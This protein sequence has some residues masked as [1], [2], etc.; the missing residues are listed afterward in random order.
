MKSSLCRVVFDIVEPATF[1]GSKIAIGVM[2]PVLPTWQI[3]SFK[4]VSFFSGGYLYAIA[5]LGT[6]D[7]VP[8]SSLN[9]RL[10]TFITAPSIPNDSCSLF[11]PISFIALKAS[12]IL[13]HNFL[14]GT[15]LNP[16]SAK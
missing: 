15:T 4:I 2:T 13:A 5:H 12:S 10:S 7:V 8:S 14:N 9:F 1:T 11:S 3:I 6:F 16:K